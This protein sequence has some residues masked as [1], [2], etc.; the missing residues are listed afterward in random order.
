MEVALR[1]IDQDKRSLVDELNEP[2]DRQKNDLVPRAKA[3]KKCDVERRS[4]VLELIQ[5]Q[6]GEARIGVQDPHSFNPAPAA[7]AIY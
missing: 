1:L 2:C 4:I 6:F 3:A 5:L 7:R